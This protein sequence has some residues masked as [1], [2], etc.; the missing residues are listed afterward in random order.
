MSSTYTKPKSVAAALAFYV[1]LTG[2]S[3]LSDPQSWFDPSR[4]PDPETYFDGRGLAMQGRGTWRM[5]RCPFHDDTTAS[6]GVN[7]VTGAFHCHACGAKGKDVLAFERLYTGHG[8]KRA[9]QDL[10]A[11]RAE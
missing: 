5:A 9:A 10:G 1:K 6:L 7:I 11:W 2:K 8:F 3:I 4:L